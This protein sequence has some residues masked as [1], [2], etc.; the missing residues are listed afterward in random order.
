M[1]RSGLSV[2]AHLLRLL[3]AFAVALGMGGCSDD[4]SSDHLGIIGARE[5]VT[6]EQTW[7]SIQ[8]SV[9]GRAVAGWENALGATF[10]YVPDQV[11]AQAFPGAFDSWNRDVEIAFAQALF[12]ADVEIDADL[13]VNGASC[14][15]SSGGTVTWPNVE[16]AIVIAGPGDASPVTYRGFA[17]LE[18]GLEGNVWYLTRWVDL[19]GAPAP[20]NEGVIC[21]T[22]GELRA[23]YRDR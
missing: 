21:P 2:S 5:A 1:S 20:W 11:S 13:I 6:P 14:P 10:E 16:Y 15:A 12:A 19:Q 7:Q 3:V 4:G 17:D 8:V 22:L 23:V 9:N 18:F